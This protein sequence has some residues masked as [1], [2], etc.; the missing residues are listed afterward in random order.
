MAGIGGD[1]PSP[2]HDICLGDVAVSSPCN[3]YRGVFI[4]KNIQ[5]ESF[6]PTKFIDQSPEILH[7]AVNG[8][9]VQY[10]RKGGRYWIKIKECNKKKIVF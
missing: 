2:K 4:G 8:L 5:D 3:D 10:E 6:K 1:A 7:A 9:I